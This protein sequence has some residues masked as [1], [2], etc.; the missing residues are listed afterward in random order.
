MAETTNGAMPDMTE[1]QQR[2][3]E[4][5]RR[6]MD[7]V[8]R[9][10]VSRESE[11]KG[12]YW[13]I[14]PFTGAGWSYMNA[15]V[16]PRHL[17]AFNRYTYLNQR[18][19]VCLAATRH[20]S[21][22][23][24]TVNI[25]VSRAAA[26]GWDIQSSVALRRKRWHAMLM[27]SSAGAAFYG[28]THFFTAHL[29]SYIK[30]GRAIFE[31]EREGNNWM[32]RV[33]GIHHL[34]PMRCIVT[35]NP[36]IPV[37]YIDKKGNAH[38]MKYYE[39]VVIADSLEPTDG[40]DAL[41]EESTSR[42][43]KKIILEATIDN[44]LYEKVS[45][46]R[47]QQLTFL[48]GVRDTT[49]GDAIAGARSEMESKGTYSFMGAVIQAILGDTP[50]EKVDIPLAGLPDGFEPRDLRDDIYLNYCDAVGL[51]PNEIDPRLAQSKNLGSG[52]QSVTLDQKQRGKGLAVWAE[53]FEDAV[54]WIV[55]DAT[56]RLYFREDS[57][58]DDIKKAQLS[59]ARADARAAMIANGEIDANVSRQMAVDQQ[60]LQSEYVPGGDATEET[61]LGD[62]DKP[63]TSED[64][65]LAD[66]RAVVQTIQPPPTQQPQTAQP[67]PKKPQTQNQ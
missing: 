27:N 15:S 47:P 56:T 59:K 6:F 49:V 5:A 17:P 26:R 34:N 50:L 62:D 42:A 3:T 28:P 38:E 40:D 35:D 64:E 54:N 58:D 46:G 14:L 9:D 51:D 12:T 10:D 48:K 31:I 60:E 20:A 36:E 55:T 25:A 45:G 22:W 67:P 7:S 33:K 61:V 29:K 63:T 65:Q 39:V 53:A 57:T 16:L 24:N 21:M 66:K 32:S 52:G 13:Y 1:V 43:W 30:T 19:M 37:V 4:E 8:K 41:W 2:V 18:D 23:A 11:D 44:Y